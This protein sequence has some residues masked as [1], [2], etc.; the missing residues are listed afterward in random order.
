MPSSKNKDVGICVNSWENTF[1]KSNSPEPIIPS[2][3][4]KMTSVLTFDVGPN[5]LLF[6]LVVMV[7]RGLLIIS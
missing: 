4:L 6:L 7:T 3:L 2:V 5:F 1:Y